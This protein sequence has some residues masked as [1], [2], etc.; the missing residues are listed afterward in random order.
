VRQPGVTAPIVG[1]TKLAQ[2][3]DLVAGLS[4]KLDDDSCR[5]VEDLYRPHPVLGIDDFPVPAPP[6]KA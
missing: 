4:L 2:F 5:L 1:V 3:D 6:P